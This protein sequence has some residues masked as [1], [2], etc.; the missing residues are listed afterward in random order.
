MAS[1]YNNRPK[2]WAIQFTA[3]DGTRPVVRLGRVNEKT[4]RAA[5]THV[6]HLLAAK[7]MGQPVPLDTAGW[8][9]SAPDK[10]HGKLAKA[11]LVPARV[12]KETAELGAFTAAVIRGRT[13]LKERTRLNLGLARKWLID[14]FGAGRDLRTINRGEAGDWHRAMKAR[15]SKAYV[16]T[17]VK[18]ARQFFKDAIDRKLITDNPLAGVKA[19]GM[20]NTDRYHY[21]SPADIEKVIAKCPDP[22]WKVIFALARYGGLRVPSET[23]ALRWGDIDFNDRRMNVRS[24]KTEHHEGGASRTVPLFPE[25]LPYL[26]DAQLDEPAMSVIAH[27]R[28]E[29]LRTTGAKIVRRA[30]LTP[31][32]K[33]FQNLRSSRETEL[34]ETFPIQVVCAWL[35]NSPEVARKHYLQVTDEHFARAAGRSAANS[36]EEAA[37]NGRKEPAPERENPRCDAG[38]GGKPVPPRGSEPSPNPRLIWGVSR[39]ALR[40]ALRRLQGTSG[41]IYQAA[42]AQ[43]RAEYPRSSPSPREEARR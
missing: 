17:L 22:E 19:G 41:V 35:G 29:N 16:A 37:G 15:H 38:L 3:P 40:K 28:G 18:K 21:V 4:A 24:P 27:H 9:A 30:G 32:G 25:L 42:K 5:L 13:D 11:G 26:L 34:A 2:Y 36:A 20:T 12:A 39:K 14:H 8:V 31:W 1:L 33:M 7:V 6:E 43:L 23:N 10:F